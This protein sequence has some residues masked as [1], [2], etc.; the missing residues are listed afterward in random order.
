MLIAS[1]VPVQVLPYCFLLRLLVRQPSLMDH[2][3]LFA[4][5][6]ALRQ[7]LAA[8][9]VTE[10]VGK[11]WGRSTLPSFNNPA[12]LIAQRSKRKSER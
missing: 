10:A 12:A 7:E 1:L 9:R 4:G 5:S 11:Q 6:A 2:T 3:L 8:C